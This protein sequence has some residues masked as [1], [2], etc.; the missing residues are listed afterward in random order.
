MPVRKEVRG[1]WFFRKRVKLP[2]GVRMDVSGYPALNTKAETARQERVAIQ[3]AIDD[4]HSPP[5]Q[6]TEV[7]T[8]DEW[9]N[10][11]YWSE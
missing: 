8:F 9:F 10:G 2:N 5:V 1:K 7:P 6:K 11:R 3:R 4:Y